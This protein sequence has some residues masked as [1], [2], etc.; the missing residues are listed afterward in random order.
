[1]FCAKD[2]TIIFSCLL[3]CILA[4]LVSGLATLFT[5]GPFLRCLPRARETAHESIV[6]IV[7]VDDDDEHF[8]A[9]KLVQTFG[10]M[11]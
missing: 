2:P 3:C 11:L 10:F 5:Y 8:C 7:F 1:M 9:E 4:S 6:Y